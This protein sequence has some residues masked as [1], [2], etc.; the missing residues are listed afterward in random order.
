M[1]ANSWQKANENE[2][3]NKLGLG[4]MNASVGPSRLTI[5][6]TYRMSR[7]SSA[8]SPSVLSIART[9]ISLTTAIEI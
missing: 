2:L 8:G 4:L 7:Q 5:A 6:I 3:K 9:G 1:R